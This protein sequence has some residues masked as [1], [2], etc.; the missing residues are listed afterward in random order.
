MKN[1]MS[2]N[3]Q[4]KKISIQDISQE[5]KLKML[6]QYP[7]VHFRVGDILEVNRKVDNRRQT[8]KAI[9]IAKHNNG[10]SS[11]FTILNHDANIM[12]RVEITTPMYSNVI[13]YK[14]ISTA[15]KRKKSK[16]YYLRYKV[17]KQAR[18]SQNYNK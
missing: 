1:N 2:S 5:L 13:D 9:C 10:I 12:D 16:L 14:V 7:K 6:N 17:G 3:I 18:I 11:S 15:K 8:L 4:K